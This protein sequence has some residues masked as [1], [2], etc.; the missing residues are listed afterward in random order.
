[1]CLSDEVLDNVEV[2]ISTGEVKWSSFADVAGD[3]VA[4]PCSNEI[5][6]QIQVAIGG[7]VQRNVSLAVFDSITATGNKTLGKILPAPVGSKMKQRDFFYR[8]LIQK[9]VSTE[10]EPAP[11]IFSLQCR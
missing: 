2:T 11:K 8:F 9:A 7:V 10:P 5:F 6:H 4:A 1:M 3:W